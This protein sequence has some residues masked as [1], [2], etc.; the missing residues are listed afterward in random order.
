MNAEIVKRFVNKNV[1]L[2]KKN[3]YAIY[4]RIIEIEYDSV[5]FKSKKT[6]SAISLDSIAEIMP[7]EG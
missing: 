5:I 2:V 4:G 6:T 7:L 3:N 1:K